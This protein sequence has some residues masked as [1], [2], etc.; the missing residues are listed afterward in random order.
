[1]MDGFRFGKPN[2]TN[3]KVLHEAATNTNELNKRRD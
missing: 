3:S 2:H 1:M